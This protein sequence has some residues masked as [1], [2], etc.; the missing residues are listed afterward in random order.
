MA[1]K[2]TAGFTLIE[3]SIVLVIIGLIVGG[4]LV[5][6]DLIR[7]AYVR[8]QISQIEKFNTAANTFYGKYQALPGDMNLTTAQASGFATVWSGTA[9][10]ACGGWGDGNGVIEGYGGNGAACGTPTGSGAGQNGETIQFWE[11]LSIANG[12]NL[13]LIEG[14]YMGAQV[15]GV[16]TVIGMPAFFPTA[17]I[18][19]GNYIFAWSGGPYYATGNGTNY[20]EIS[21]PISI[22][23]YNNV[24]TSSGLTVAEAY[25]IDRKTDDGFPQSGNVTALTIN[26]NF[27]VTWASG[28]PFCWAATC[29]AMPGV[30]ASASVTTCYDNGGNAS[31]PM[32]YSTAY[33]KGAGLNCTLSFKMQAGD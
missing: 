32:V 25:N 6:Q 2:E 19:R 16:N 22:A 9:R 10:G 5:G 3:L 29:G 31:N 14:S 30:A 12:L 17:K 11:E 4:V 1:N 18:G 21:I 28:V 7:A 13:N 8:A 26:S 24:S 27:N 20:F 23:S 15:G 33:Q